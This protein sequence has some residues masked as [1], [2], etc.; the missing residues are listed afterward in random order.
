MGY[1]P[2]LS[3]RGTVFFSPDQDVSEAAVE[4]VRHCH[5][6]VLLIGDRFGSEFRNTGRS[7]TNAEYEKA[8]SLKIPIFALVYEPVEQDLRTYEANL[9]N[10]E[11]DAS[12]IRYG[13][14]DS[15]AIFDFIRQV[16]S[17]ALN[18]ALQPFR[19]F[20]DIESYLKSQWAG[21][22]HSYLTRHMEEERVVNT[23]DEIRGIGQKIESLSALIAEKVNPDGLQS[24]ERVDGVRRVAAL[25]R[26]AGLRE[27]STVVDFKDPEDLADHYQLRLVNEVVDLLEFQLDY[28]RLRGLSK[29]E[30]QLLD[31][32][33]D[34]QGVQPETRDTFRPTPE[35]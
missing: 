14:V 5:L 20:S 8:F 6:F 4:D 25:L 19:T 29:S 35:T 11:I 10:P 12:L 27:L 21:L 13:S 3:E 16:R 33:L 26:E 7:V 1:E 9:K 23:L 2:V 32:L 22:L 28:R 31:W 24:L 15:S 17:A 30:F 18:N 34:R